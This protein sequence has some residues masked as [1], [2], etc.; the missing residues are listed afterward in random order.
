MN[1]GTRFSSALGALNIKNKDLANEFNISSQN[2]S[3]LKK[4]NKLNDTMVKISNFYRIDLNWLFSGKGHMFIDSCNVLQSPPTPNHKEALDAI[5]V[6][7]AIYTKDAD[8]EDDF[9]SCVKEW[10]RRNI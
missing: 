2:V 10:V 9:I 8:K 4:A 7:Q 6:A 5:E 3:N 1:I